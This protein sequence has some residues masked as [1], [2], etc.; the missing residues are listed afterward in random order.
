MASL[1]ALKVCTKCG[2]EQPLSAFHTDTT[3]P[4]GLHP[5]CRAC[6][7]VYRR[8]RAMIRRKTDSGYRERVNASCM[9]SHWKH[10][11]KRLASM[12][13]KGTDY[14]KNSVIKSLYGITLEEY[15]GMAKAQGNVCAICHE[16]E[17]RKNRFSG[18]CRLHIDHDHKTKVIRGLL[19]SRCN[20]GLG[21]FRERPDL[22][23][24]AI[25]YLKKDQNE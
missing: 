2:Q 4:D 10:R 20:A 19:C 18:I 7:G 16:P 23:E 8:R 17:T 25:T 1:I 22:L 14:I 3:R 11:N 5:H 24:S 21:Y 6:R 12:K 15:N 13:A 9:K